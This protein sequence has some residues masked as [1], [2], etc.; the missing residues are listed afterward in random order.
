MRPS[1][2]AGIFNFVWENGDPLIENQIINDVQQAVA[3]WEPNV[4]I[5]QIDFV[6][7]PDYS[8]VVMLDIQFS[9]GSAPTTYSVTVTLGGV[10]VEVTT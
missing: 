1:Y 9:V 3:V 8:G 2:G 5:N 10:G 4:T 7:Q 6:P